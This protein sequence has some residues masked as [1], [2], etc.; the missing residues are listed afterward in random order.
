[1]VRSRRPKTM[2]QVWD[3][4]GE[5]AKAQATSPTG[6]VR[7][8]GIGRVGLGIGLPS[9]S[10]ERF[11]NE[12]ST[13]Y[14]GKISKKPREWKFITK[15]FFRKIK[16]PVIDVFKEAEEIQIIIDLGNF[17]Q[18]EL[19]FDLKDSK[20]IISGKHEDC[21]FYEEIP[22]PKDADIKK[23]KEIFRN[24]ILELIIPKKDSKKWRGKNE[25]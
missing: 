6:S 23:M 21:E 19:N 3:R 25:R 24:N 20:Y 7:R 9:K 15:P 17:S 11:P 14:K 12:I 8:G 2:R 4:E 16:E 1:M 13:N 5:L 18:G 22:L 10:R